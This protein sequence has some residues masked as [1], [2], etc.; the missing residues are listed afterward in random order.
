M[1]LQHSSDALKADVPRLHAWDRGVFFR[2]PLQADRDIVLAAAL[3]SRSL[4][5]GSSG[6]QIP[7]PAPALHALVALVDSSRGPEAIQFASEAVKAGHRHR[8]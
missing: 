3:R 8:I 5:K 2:A 6:P 4:G 7:A 1:A